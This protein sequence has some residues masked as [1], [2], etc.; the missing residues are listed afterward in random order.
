MKFRHILQLTIVGGWFLAMFIILA[1]LLIYGEEWVNP[2]Y[3]R[4]FIAA[5]GVV[6]VPL[7]L[8]VFHDLK[9]EKRKNSK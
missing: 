5:G 1:L 8:N 2:S 9:K 4:P 7:W 6:V 3:M